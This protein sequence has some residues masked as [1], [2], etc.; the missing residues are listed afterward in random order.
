MTVYILTYND[1]GSDGKR[2]IYGV[3]SNEDAAFDALN[4]DVLYPMRDYFDTEEELWEAIDPDVE[5]WKVL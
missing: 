2:S 4:D 3:Y 5:E 1:L